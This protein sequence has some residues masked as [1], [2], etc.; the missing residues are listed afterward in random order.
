MPR[1]T[2]EVAEARKLQQLLHEK[3]RR[4]ASQSLR[5]Y[6]DNVLIDSVPEP[7]LYGQIR[8][9]WQK[10]RDDW[11]VPA[12]EFAAG[13]NPDYKGPTNFLF[14]YSKGHHKSG[15]ISS[16]LSWMTGFSKR[17]LRMY[18]GAKDAE[19][20]GLIRNFMQR[21]AALNKWM[22][23]VLKFTRDCVEGVRSG[24][25]LEIMASDAGGSQG[26]LSDLILC[27]ELTRWDDYEFFE[28]LYSGVHKRAGHCV[29]IV[30][31]NA[32]I[33]GSWQDKVRQ[34]A[35][36]EHGGRWFVYEQPECT[37]LASWLRKEEIAQDRKLLSPAEAARLYDNRWIDPTEDRGAFSPDDI[38]ACVGEPRQ[39]P[40]GADV[41]FGVD[42]GGVRDRTAL[43]VMWFDGQV[44]HVTD[45]ACWQGN[46]NNEVKVSDI[47]A[48]L[49]QKFAVYP[50]ATAVFDRHQMLATIQRLELEG[51]KV[52]RFDYAGGRQNHALLENLRTLLQNRR[53]RYS[54]TVGSHP[55]D[56][57]TLV[58]EL[59]SVLKKK[60]AYGFRIDHENGLNDDR[61]IA[62]GMAAL[63]AVSSS[64]PPP[65]RQLNNKPPQQSLP[66]R[67]GGG[68]SIDHFSKRGW[69][70]LR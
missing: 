7:K 5:A 20:A 24:S 61:V 50:N 27:D 19:Q 35:K 68:F 38:D 36:E 46:H 15:L 56:G 39:P 49:D 14:T 31:S 67:P 51:R 18:A 21:E 30:L 9:P 58:S 26:L 2:K 66:F 10:Q 55:Y 65:Q 54:A 37:T 16:V 6:L 57:T 13:V 63:E 4:E 62:V 29:F 32:G 34:L 59:K 69:F 3:L 47:D 23:P 70:N 22:E 25:T 44:L 11:L 1:P 60:M 52:V 8:E 42:Y 43:A 33:L 41:F 53:I 48:W 64:T 28:S 45:V 12:L 17:P 40:S